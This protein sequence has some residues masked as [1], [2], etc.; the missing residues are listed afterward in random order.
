M[1]KR[2]FGNK[3]RIASAVATALATLLPSAYAQSQTPS[4]SGDTGPVYNL[5]RIT[6]ISTRA[7][8]TTEESGR[9]ITLIQRDELDREQ[10]QSIAAALSSEPNIDSVGGP[11]PLNQSVNIRGL[12]NSRVLQTL[13]GVRQNFQSGH[14]PDY[15]L[16]PELVSR[17]EVIKGPA[18]SLWGSGA[19]GGVVA[20]QSLSP[21]ELMPDGE[22]FGGLLKTGHNNNNDLQSSVSAVA[23]RQGSLGWLLG[24]YYRDGNNL[25]HGD[26]TTLE[27]SEMLDRGG[28]AKLEW[29]IDP[30]QSLNLS[31]LEVDTDGQVP[32]NGAA[33]ITSTSNFLID[34]ETRSRNLRM[35]YNL[36]TDSPL[37]NA[38]LILWRN[39]VEMDETRVSD[40]RADS[41]EL[42]AYG[43][44]F[45]NQSDLN[46]WRLLYGL[47][48]YRESFNGERSGGSRPN[49][50][51]AESDHLGLFLQARLDLTRSW[52]AE[53]GGR[54]D[55]FSTEA[56]GLGDR[57][58][59]AF[60]PAASIRWTPVTWG[61]LTLRHE[62][63]FRAPSSEEM[64]TTG[65]HFCMFPGF[66]NTF[67][68]NPNL[69][70]EEAANTE[71]IAGG[72]W[73]GLLGDDDELRLKL[74]LFE[75]RV[76]NFIE[77][78][79]IDPTFA[80]VMDP[81]YTT[82]INVDEARL[83]G[84]ELS[85]TYRVQG[86]KVK[87]GYGVTRGVDLD[88]DEDLTNIPADTLKAD[89]SYSFLDDRLLTGVNIE[90]ARDQNRTDYEENSASTRYGGYTLSDLYA[91]W[92]PAM[93]PGLAVDLK[94]NNLTDKH[95]RQAW[96][97]LDAAGR[98][99]ILST[100]YRF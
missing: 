3:T 75:N 5:D 46:R 72:H 12:S 13:D 40:G 56:T 23:G 97:S 80:P 10:A 39:E 16:P 54:I 59:S 44:N 66:C 25:E 99:V 48:G 58:D 22:D 9:S 77:Q 100:T 82:W 18:S 47:D 51:D 63:A 74:A 8:E 38:E 43:F 34:R 73:Q 93:A 57:S 71:L 29:Q 61:G 85:S 76:D 84:F 49:P 2:C 95:Y 42:D 78:I 91:R 6:I 67:V 89:L 60:S 26:G 65:T 24:G 96:E 86:L 19:I 14:R 69:D 88:T 31:Y 92:S 30:D 52:T 62:R 87:L 32:S 70:S 35:G 81:G 20:L 4:D 27:G 83:R 68:S 64:Y 55:H 21:H 33:V 36:N 37:L 90:H 98:E 94:I 15:L 79:V 45:S 53:I 17:I 7:R 28:L 41:T 11:R 50:P 1:T